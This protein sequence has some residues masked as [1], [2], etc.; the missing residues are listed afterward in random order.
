MKTSDN[1]FYPPTVIEDT[2][3][4]NDFVRALGEFV[5]DSQ[6]EELV[7]GIYSNIELEDSGWPSGLAM[8]LKLKDRNALAALFEED[9]FKVKFA[10]KYTDVADP[11]EVPEWI[12]ELKKF[13]I[14]ERPRPKSRARQIRA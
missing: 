7:Q 14:R 13:F 12:T 10:L 3:N 8:N 11:V 6:Y 4:A 1:N 2:L 5:G 9:G